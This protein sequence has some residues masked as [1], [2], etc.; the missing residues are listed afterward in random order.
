M[1]KDRKN[2]DGRKDRDKKILFWSLV[3]FS[4]A[5]FIFLWLTSFSPFSKTINEDEVKN[6]LDWKTFSEKMQTNWSN[7]RGDWQEVKDDSFN[8]TKDIFLNSSSTN[9]EL[10]EMASSTK[11]NVSTPHIESVIFSET[12]NSVDIDND[13][14]EQLKKEINNLNNNFKTPNC[15]EWINCMPTFSDNHENVNTCQ[16]PVGCEGITQIAY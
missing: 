15:P 8:E 4:M 10:N 7:F 2:N 3:T 6:T 1:L 16:I 11:N 14:L 12:N 9:S 5:V 13:S